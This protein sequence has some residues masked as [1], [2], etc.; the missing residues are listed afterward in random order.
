MFRYMETPPPIADQ[1]DNEG[2]SK[3]N[4]WEMSTESVHAGEMHDASG[5]HID[6]IHMTSTYIFEDSNA[7]KSWGSGE[8]GAHVY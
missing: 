5:A 7:I 3:W 8:S 2:N 6:P 1:M 4:D